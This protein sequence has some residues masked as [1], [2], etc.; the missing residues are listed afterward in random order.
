M[1]NSLVEDLTAENR[2]ITKVENTLSDI[3]DKSTGV[4]DVLDDLIFFA[5]DQT[6]EEYL[7][8]S[9]CF[10]VLISQSDIVIAVAIAVVAL[11][12]TSGIIYAINWRR[13]FM[14]EYKRQYGYD[15]A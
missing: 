4:A 5:H 15:H 9:R 10:A 2:N 8:T 13:D 11:G 7:S 12:C 3:M 14:K 1:V 6:I